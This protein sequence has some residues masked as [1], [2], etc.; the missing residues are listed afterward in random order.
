VETDKCGRGASASANSPEAKQVQP[1]GASVQTVEMTFGRALKVWWSYTWRG[2]VL[3]IPLSLVM[4]I[5]MFFVMPHPVPGQKPDPAQFRAMFRT[6][7]L[8]W[9]IIMVG[10]VLLQ[11]QAMRWMLKTRWSDFRLE[12]TNE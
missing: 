11:A 12:A 9:L 2:M 1:K 6:L 7:P 3:T 10:S 5:F 4:V 8:F